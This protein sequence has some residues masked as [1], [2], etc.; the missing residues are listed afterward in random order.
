MESFLTS[1]WYGNSP[2]RWLLAP[3][4]PIYSL[5]Q[6]FDR[7]RV[8]P[9]SADA[10][11]VVVGNLT[12]GGTG[13]TPIVA[14]LAQAL[15]KRGY[16]IGLIAR[17]YGGSASRKGML[18]EADSDPDDVGDEALML[19]RMTNV[20]VAIGRHRV[21]AAKLLLESA[22]VDLIISD[23][24]LQHW[25]LERDFEIC[26]LDGERGLGNGHCLPAGPLREPK[27]RLSEMDAVLVNGGRFEPT[28]DYA[29]FEL[30]L[31]PVATSLGA[32]E[33]SVLDRFKGSRV[34]A[35]AGIGNPER[36]FSNLEAF[37][38][39]IVRHPFP[40]H[41]AYSARDLS[42]AESAPVLMTEKDAVKCERL[43]VKNGWVVSAEV[44][45]PNGDQLIDELLTAVGVK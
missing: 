31:S 18:V 23:D 26:V 21:H 28:V 5:L 41:H 1:I 3:L 8:K 13:K 43:G 15:T 29:R 4:V 7:R 16:K 9:A 27:E 38:L 10:P 45:L 42:F 33:P 6:Q 17:G 20:P 19:R 36:F 39:T 25:A 14:W 32:N 2:L 12:V 40:D 35:L 30:E 24:G 34:H 44:K 22:A 37:G 11:V